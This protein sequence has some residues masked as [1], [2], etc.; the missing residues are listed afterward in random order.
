MTPQG[1]ERHCVR[2]L[3]SRLA[4]AL[5]KIEALEQEL[6]DHAEDW[7]MAGIPPRSEMAVKLTRHYH[8]RIQERADVK[9]LDFI[10]SCRVQISEK[11]SKVAFA[12]P[13]EMTLRQGIDA[14]IARGDED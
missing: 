8:K 9:R 10:E 13:V 5:A 1:S 3:G 12:F 11:Q 7:A 14:A 4:T 6:L 2:E